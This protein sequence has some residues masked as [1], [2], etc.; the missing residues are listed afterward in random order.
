L[1]DPKGIPPGIMQMVKGLI[2]HKNRPENVEE[3]AIATR[4]L[5]ELSSKYSFQIWDVELTEMGSTQ[6]IKREF[7]GHRLK[8]HQLDVLKACALNY[9]SDMLVTEEG[10]PVLFG[11]QHN[12]YAAWET[13]K[14]LDREC[15]RLCED[16]LQRFQA[17]TRGMDES[18]PLHEKLIKYATAP[19]EFRH[20]FLKGAGHAIQWKMREIRRARENTNTALVV[21]H[22]EDIDAMMGDPGDSEVSKE[23]RIDLIYNMGRLHALN[24]GFE[25]ELH[26]G[27]DHE[28]GT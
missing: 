10:E 1:S 14:Y 18:N 23:D 13:Y 21:R 8:P 17:N 15:E 22:Q 4:K 26:E 5:Q 19:V 16:S 3:A 2:A 6:V 25:N 7:T 20:N 24:I 12:V 27:G 11:S 9:F 28:A